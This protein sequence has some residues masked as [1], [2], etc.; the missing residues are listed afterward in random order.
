MPKEKTLSP[1]STRLVLIVDDEPD[2]AATLKGLLGDSGVATIVAGGI[3]EARQI[4]EEQ[5][6][7]PTEIILDG[8]DGE[9]SKV[10]ALAG[11]IPLRVHSSDNDV[12][13]AAKAAGVETVFKDEMS[14][15]F[16]TLVKQVPVAG[17]PQ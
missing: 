1:L 16:D 2:V 14:L 11:A 13:K 10:V 7:K 3:E 4:L 8:L 15:S 6:L 17:I 12:L 9:W 5:K